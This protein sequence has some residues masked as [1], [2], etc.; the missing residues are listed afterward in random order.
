MTRDCREVRP[1]ASISPRDIALTQ[2]NMYGQAAIDAPTTRLASDQGPIVT[3]LIAAARGIR[4][5]RLRPAAVGPNGMKIP[6]KGSRPSPPYPPPL[7]FYLRKVSP[8]RRRTS[9]APRS[10]AS[11][12]RPRNGSPASRLPSLRTRVPHLLLAPG[13]VCAVPLVLAGELASQSTLGATGRARCFARVREKPT[14]RQE[15]G[16]W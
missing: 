10:S 7:R 3:I 6:S 12:P 15:F 8:A 9:W 14:N 13:C 5:P 1:K 11:D 2:P 4:S 16:G